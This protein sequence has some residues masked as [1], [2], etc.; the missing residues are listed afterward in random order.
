MVA[1]KEDMPTLAARYGELKLPV[2]I[3]Y[4]REDNLLDWRKHG[5]RTAGEIAGAELELVDGGHMLP[6]TAPDLTARFIRKAAGED[7]VEAGR[8]RG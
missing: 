7:K 2:G 1:I 6:F 8:A 4:A 3:L 5:E